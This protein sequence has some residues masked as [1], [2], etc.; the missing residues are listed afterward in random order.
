MRDKLLN[1]TARALYSMINGERPFPEDKMQKMAPILEV[2]T[3][4]IKGWILADKYH[5]NILE[6]AVNT[7]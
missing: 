4:E 1:V 7:K 6:M 2:S 3:K 5:K